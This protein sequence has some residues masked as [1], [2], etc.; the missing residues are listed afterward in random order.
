MAVIGIGTTSRASTEDVLEIVAAARAKMI[1]VGT[2]KYPSPLPLSR[3]G[4]GENATEHGTPFTRARHTPSPLAG[5]GWGEGE[6]LIEALASLDRPAINGVLQAAARLSGLDLILLTLDEL[7]AAAH[8]CVTHSEKS[9]KHYGIP[10]VAEAAALA[11]AGAG[12]RLLLPRFCGRN[13]TAS[14]AAAP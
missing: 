6:Q 5:E 4:R 3:K 9:M 1:E 10:S 13:T 12:A 14:V 11:A 2:S 8:L 7:Q